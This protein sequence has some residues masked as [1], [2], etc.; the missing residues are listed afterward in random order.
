MTPKTKFGLSS[1]ER[2][3]HAEWCDSKSGI[4]GTLSPWRAREREPITGVWAQS[5]QRGPGAEPLVRSPLNL[6]DFSFW[7][8]VGSSKFAIF[9]SL[10]AANAVNHSFFVISTIEDRILLLSAAMTRLQSML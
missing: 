6:K 9:Y 4:T 3:N 1:G 7:T 2:G 8:S 5:P 10:Y